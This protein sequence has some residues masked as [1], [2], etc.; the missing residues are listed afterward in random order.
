MNRVRSLAVA[1]LAVAPA[2]ADDTPLVSRNQT[3]LNQ[4]G[5]EVILAA[6]QAKAAVM[7]LTLNIAVADDGGHLLGFVRMDGARPAS[8]YT[9]LTKA[10]AA[11]TYR[12]PTGPI[13]PAG[14]PNVV[15]SLGVPAAAAASGGKLTPL[16]GGLP[17]VVD[18]QVIGAVGV[19]GGT[20]EQDAEVAQ[21]GIDAL[22]RAVG[23]GPKA[24]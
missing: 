11:A 3:R 22:L 2:A 19:G 1:L 10:T 21:A 15:L 17:V 16:K 23:A 13:P 12:Q 9:A 8:A 18:G 14:E 5:V 6:A 7:K 24:P 20:G 4:K